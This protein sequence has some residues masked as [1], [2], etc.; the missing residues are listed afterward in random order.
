MNIEKIIKNKELIKNIPIKIN[1][2]INNLK[3]YQKDN[4]QYVLTSFIAFIIAIPFVDIKN[5]EGSAFLLA[6]IPSIL[7]LLGINSVINSFIRKGLNLKKTKLYNLL[8]KF[9]YEDYAYAEKS[10]QN[11][12]KEFSKNTEL[13]SDILS[14]YI[15]NYEDQ[16]I[17]NFRE[18][19]YETLIELKLK[20]MTELELSEKRDYIE[21]AIEE[22]NSE[23]KVKL[24]SYIIKKI[25]QRPKED[26]IIL[27]EKNIVKI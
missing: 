16:K 23:E 25:G 15:E 13:V 4:F 9:N 26:K 1:N 7:V 18:R 22:L 21:K 6:F 8:T 5:I 19:F 2:E 14:F 10:K 17:Y 12:I 27:K 24:K 20:K 11:V 3:W